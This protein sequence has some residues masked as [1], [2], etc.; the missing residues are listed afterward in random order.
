MKLIDLHS[1]LRHTFKLLSWCSLF[2]ARQYIIHIN[3]VIGTILICGGPVKQRQKPNMFAL[4]KIFF[5]LTGVIISTPYISISKTL[6]HSIEDLQLLNFKI[7]Y[8]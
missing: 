7:R 2:K 8:C 5:K 3:H 6:G 4:L 1:F